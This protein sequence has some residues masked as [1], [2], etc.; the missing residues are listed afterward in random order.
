MHALLFPYTNKYFSGQLD[1]ELGVSSLESLVQLAA[2]P[3][4]QNILTEVSK[5]GPARN[6]DVDALNALARGNLS[7]AMDAG[8]KATGFDAPR[9]VCLANVSSAMYQ[10]SQDLEAWPKGL[11]LQMVSSYVLAGPLSRQVPRHLARLLVP[12]FL[13]AYVLTHTHT[14]PLSVC[15]SLSLRSFFCPPLRHRF[16]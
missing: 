11:G 12:F 15:A 4:N 6:R 16:L 5:L 10:A 3:E 2:T 14:H 1:V 9:A 13:P 7:L 8:A